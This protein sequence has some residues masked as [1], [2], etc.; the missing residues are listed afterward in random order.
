MINYKKTTIMII[1]ILFIAFTYNTVSAVDVWRGTDWISRGALIKSSYMKDN[2]NFLFASLNADN[3]YRAPSGYAPCTP[4]NAGAV[5]FTPARGLEG[6]DGVNW[7]IFLRPP[8]NT[9]GHCIS[10][11]QT[12][13]C[14]IPY[15]CNC[16][17]GGCSTCFMTGTQR[18]VVSVCQP[19]SCSIPYSCNCGKG[20]CST[21]FMTDTL[22]VCHETEWPDAW[23]ACT[24]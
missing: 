10:V 14:S 18:R 23:S 15:S 6:C 24:K 2:Y 8:P 16:G 21:C 22:G 13:S 12:Q 5:R 4:D 20:G 9:F 1:A 7:N 19:Y 3:G 17:K 11:E